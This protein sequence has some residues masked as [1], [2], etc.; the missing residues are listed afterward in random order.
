MPRLSILVVSNLYPPYYVGGYELGCRDVVDELTSRGH[1]VSVLT[2]TWGVAEPCS[3]GGVHRRLQTNMGWEQRSALTNF[4]RLA[5]KEIVNRRAFLR[6]ARESKPDVVYFW[7]MGCLSIFLAFDAQRLG[8]KCAY[9]ISDD[10]LAN[11]QK[12]SWFR[13]T[14][15]NYASGFRRIGQ[16][17]LRPVFRVFRMSP[18]GEL[19]L[20][21]VQ[22]AS[23]Y[24][25][26]SAIAAGKPVAEAEVI[27]WGIDVSRFAYHP[28]LTAPKRILFVGQVVPQK[29]VHTAVEAMNILVN[30]HARHDVRLTVVGGSI[31]PDYVA[32]MRKLADSYGLKQYVEFTGSVPREQ[33]PSLYQQHDILVF[34]SVWNEPF[35]ISLLEG[36]ASGLA[37]VATPTGGSAEIL[38]DGR[39]ALVFPREDAQT[40]AARVLCLVDN[41]DFFEKIRQNGR[42]TVETRFCFKNMVD[43]IEH[44][45][46][47]I[48]AL[49]DQSSCRDLVPE[50]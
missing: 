42:R 30:G 26:R 9:Y 47:D 18:R 36:F 44:S 49:R 41:P 3:Q 22:F 37:V 33:L 39:N 38:E 8:L 1:T 13:L 50:N 5:R 46:Y 25:K 20:D 35:S 32:E 7:N 21:H 2:S 45:L 10:W 34:P 14:R 11:W 43:K 17:A 19:R 31:A 16:K 23:E 28:R 29:G 24:L 4:L 15:G 6:L 12:D 40:C 27:R 48:A